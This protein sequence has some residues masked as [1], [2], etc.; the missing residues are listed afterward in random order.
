MYEGQTS[1]GNGLQTGNTAGLTPTDLANIDVRQLRDILSGGVQAL[2]RL[3]PM[4]ETAFRRHSRSRA[5]HLL[6]KSI[7]GLFG[8]YL[9]VVLP[10]G[11][12]TSDAHAT[13]WFRY[14][15]VPIGAV[16][17]AILLATRV[18]KLDSY[19]EVTL[20]FGV[21]FCLSGTIYGAMLL[22]NNYL[23][24]VAAFET[25]Y[26][27]FV[28]FSVLRLSTLL[29]LR[30]ALSAFVVA[31]TFALIN[32]IQPS[33]LNALLYFFV[34]LLIC[35]INGYML[36]YAA[37][38]DFIQLL[39]SRQ[40]SQL[41]LNELRSLEV[42]GADFQHVMQ[43]ALGRVCAHMGW[44]AGRVSRYQDNKKLIPFTHFPHSDR[45]QE[46]NQALQLQ[47]PLDSVSELASD[48]AMQGRALWRAEQLMM[49]ENRPL[50]H[51]A[52]P[53]TS[54]S[55]LI[56]VQEFFSMRTEV[57][58]AVMLEM[59]EQV[60]LQ[61]T[62]IFERDRQQQQLQNMASH[63]GLTGVA[64]RVYMLSAIREAL[65]R[66]QDNLQHSFALLFLDVDRFKWVNDSL[67]HAAGD[68]LLASLA[69]RLQRALHE[70]D[71]IARVGGDEFAVL[72]DGISGQQ[73]AIDAVH[74]IQE[75]LR[76]PVVLEDNHIEMGVTVGIALGNRAYKKAEELLRD[77]DT[78]KSYA[79]EECR[80]GYS[81]FADHMLE[82]VRHRLKL[83][84]DLKNAIEKNELI[85]HYQPIV[86]LKT[87]RLSGFE[88]L[89]R[90]R[91]AEQGW[92]MP[93]MFISLAEETGLMTP[94]TR[95]LLRQAAAQL[96]TWRREIPAAA[97]MSVSVNLSADYFAAEMTP[98]E[99][100][101]IIRQTGLTPDALRL[102]ITET[103]IIANAD[104]CMRNI[105]LFRQAGVQIYIDDFGTGYSSLNYL[106][107]FRANALK[108]D[109]S[110]VQHLTQGGNDAVIVKTISSLGNSLGMDV[111]AEGVETI[112]QLRAVQELGC[113]YVQGY[114]ISKP[115][116]VEAATRLINLRMT[117]FFA[118]EEDKSSQSAVVGKGF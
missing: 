34:P 10:V 62:R 1:A 76:Q 37:R 25:I 65:T 31:G 11:V 68:G 64:N 91:H 42:D 117:D 51:L 3:P 114:L 67:G 56:A 115:M 105:Q 112:E 73:D 90:W 32:D 71:I 20:G 49:D 87:G 57:P 116:A 113:D 83:T 108:I 7:F 4:L 60:G 93:D 14:A 88:S 61:F 47:W 24:Q 36:E 2:L 110:F 85:L 102:E 22:G 66:H 30:G 16:L 15:V 94:M 39:C 46:W 106:T 27:L 107:R 96:S 98:N 28:A 41:L 89:V 50:T 84:T 8:L 69:Q 26:V 40:E 100:I 55:H 72:L 48:A 23:G 17:F 86:C 54:D 63:D 99:V 59:M 12:L 33:W 92:L 79:K 111:I 6:R 5:A 97:N 9:L 78:A 104:A 74:R 80:G 101:T 70:K 13:V 53:V 81:I 35:A 19:V 18:P 38:R 29:A 77:A 52:F 58:D 21:F 75:Q 82:R 95:Q 109:R 43:I 44:I 103:Q 45:Q 118:V